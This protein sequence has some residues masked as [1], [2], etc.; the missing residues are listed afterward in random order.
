MS[1]SIFKGEVKAGDV[2]AEFKS[3]FSNIDPD[4]LIMSYS[5]TGG[6]NPQVAQ[7]IA[8]PGAFARVNL[9]LPRQGVLE[10][11]V[12]I[13]HANDSGRLTVTRPGKPAHDE[14]I[15]GSVRWVYAVV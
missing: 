13:G 8:A 3:D 6:A 2:S 15:Q 9:T 12:V 1:D 11:W 10:V 4:L 14:P 7:D 5:E